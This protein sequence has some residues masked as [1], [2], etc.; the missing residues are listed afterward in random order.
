MRLPVTSVYE[1]LEKR[2][3]VSTRTLAA[4][5]FVCTR[6]IWI[7]LVTYT[8]SFAISA[9]TGWK[10]PVIAL[11]IFAIAIFFATAGGISAVIWMSV[12]KFAI[13]FGGAIL[14]P[15]YILVLTGAGPGQWWASFA[16]A[17]RA[18]VPIFSF[19]A[20]I[21]IT[22]I[23]VQQMC[24]STFD[25]LC[26]HSSYVQSSAAD[27]DWRAFG[28]PKLHITIELGQAYTRFRYSCPLE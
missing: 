1:Y 7:G 28:L 18:T 10:I 6:I 27:Q 22:I 13:L 26:A 21:R 17:G 15:I 25:L 5:V 14:V 20:T 16:Q 9:I 8:A 4:A 19:D 3:G 24:C 23:G 11:V 12:V 2:Y